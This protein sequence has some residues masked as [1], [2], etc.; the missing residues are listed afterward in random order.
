MEGCQHRPDLI[1]R[2]LIG[3]RM[4]AEY[5][6][7]YLVIDRRH[8]EVF[9]PHQET[10]RFI[11]G[12]G[13]IPGVGTRYQRFPIQPR[14]QRRNGHAPLVK[15]LVYPLRFEQCP[16]SA[17]FDRPRLHEVALAVTREFGNESI[18]APSMVFRIWP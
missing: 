13:F 5:K 16:C 6:V 11:V 7:L 1:G 3:G 10:Q 4:M 12:A 8:M 18:D 2:M 15:D 14:M 9:R 17:M